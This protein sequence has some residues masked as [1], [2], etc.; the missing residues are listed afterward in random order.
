MEPLELGNSTAAN[1]LEH[2]SAA[3]AAEQDRLDSSSSTRDSSSSSSSGT[4]RRNLFAGTAAMVQQTDADRDT[5]GDGIHQLY[6]HCRQQQQEQGPEVIQSL[7]PWFNLSRSVQELSVSFS[8][9]L[10]DAELASLGDLTGLRTCD[11]LACHFFTG[12]AW[13]MPLPDSGFARFI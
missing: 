4:V 2:S 6:E 9:G 12:M 5:C 11:L 13:H 1:P 3:A 10:C 7:Q 8:P